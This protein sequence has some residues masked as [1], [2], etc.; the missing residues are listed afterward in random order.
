MTIHYSNT[1]TSLNPRLLQ[2]PESNIKGPIR[3]EQHPLNGDFTGFGELKSALLK[4]YALLNG[5]S[6]VASADTSTRANGA[7][8]ESVKA[9]LVDSLK[10]PPRLREQVLKA[11]L[12]K[13]S[14]A[15]PPTAQTLRPDASSP[16]S[17]GSA[18][19]EVAGLMRTHLTVV[20]LAR[21]LQEQLAPKGRSSPALSAVL[22][23][24]VRLPRLREPKWV[25]NFHKQPSFPAIR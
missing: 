15:Y 9:V 25:L 21:S 11:F 22:A 6:P 20:D 4:Q 19:A 24:E 10:L 1:V 5:R 23:T 17:D 7:L 12:D 16:R 13:F 14:E 18:N 3:G 2:R 8:F